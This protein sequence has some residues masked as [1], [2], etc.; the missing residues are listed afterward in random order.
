MRTYPYTK[1]TAIWIANMIEE[2]GY[3]QILEIGNN[4]SY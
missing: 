4:Y 3:E 2:D 1:N